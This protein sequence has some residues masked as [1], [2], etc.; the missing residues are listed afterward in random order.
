MFWPE[1]NIVVSYKSVLNLNVTSS[2]VRDE[3]SYY[4]DEITN[5]TRVKASV[6]QLRKEEGNEN[7]QSKK[8]NINQIT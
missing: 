8:D 7:M 2:E 5:I 4:Y 1:T 6:K 3:K